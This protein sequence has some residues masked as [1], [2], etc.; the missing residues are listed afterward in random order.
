[1]PI[2]LARLDAPSAANDAQ[3]QPMNTQPTQPA[4]GG[5]DLAKLDAP[6][7]AANQPMQ[8]GGQNN[9]AIAPSQQ[10]AQPSSPSFLDKISDLISP[11]SSDYAVQLLDKSQQQRDQQAQNERVNYAKEAG[12]NVP[13]QPTKFS[14]LAL[15]E[16]ADQPQAKIIALA[17]SRFP[18]MPL[19]QAVKR[20]GVI[21][22]HIVFVGDDGQMY[23]EDQPS[24]GA[25]LIGHSPTIAGN[26]IGGGAGVLAGGGIGSI[27]TGI[28]GAAGGS[29]IGEGIRNA[30]AHYAL[31]ENKTPG[32]IAT[33][34]ATEG[35]LGAANQATGELA[36]RVILPAV[37]KGGSS[38]YNKIVSKFTGKPDINP[39]SVIASPD[40]ASF[41]ADANKLG[42]NVSKAE[43][44][45]NKAD[46]EQEKQLRGLP[47][48]A[49]KFGEAD[50]IRNPQIRNAVTG[51]LDSVAPSTNVPG[52]A[53]S[54]RYA[55]QNAIKQADKARQSAAEPFYQQAYASGAQVDVDPVVNYIND[56]LKTA[57]GQTAAALQRTL[58]LLKPA[59]QP[60][61]QVFD[62]SVEG[63]HNAK[64]EVDHMINAT[65]PDSL[66]RTAKEQLTT[67]KNQLVDQL[68]QA[69]PEYEQG[70]A[71]FAAE[72]APYNQLQNSVIGK[73]ADT[74]DT[75]LK[76]VAST[77]FDPKQ[78]DPR[79]LMQAKQVIQKQN[80]DAWNAITRSYLQQ[81]FEGMKDS[82][83]NGASF[84]KAF[85][86][87]VMG[88][89]KQRDML[90]TALSDNP[91]ALENFK[92]IA[93][94]MPR[95]GIAGDIGSP[96][97]TRLMA[98]AKDSALGGLA[99]GLAGYMSGGEEGAKTGAL[100]GVILGHAGAKAYQKLAFTIMKS[101]KAALAEA[102][103]NPKYAPEMAAIRKLNP[104]SQQA[105]NA[106]TDLV[107]RIG[108]D[109]T[110]NQFNYM[111]NQAPAAAN[112]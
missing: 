12:A 33:G 91:E 99:G 11:P 45:G 94:V 38:I 6:S 80:P 103:L 41:Q 88:T 36:G 35:V 109:E 5:I 76:N 108:E 68:K 2:D 90:M 72:S 73:I 102:V 87:K 98:M 27:A 107:T 48:S 100:T 24:I 62:T 31:D 16:F 44:T 26:I 69:S 66:G 18:N 89:Q 46:I 110:A 56:Q 81:Q 1:M 111:P 112:Q 32:D 60:E 70:R 20:Y 97:A 3:S 104:N 39:E 23:A 92:L 82:V 42:L 13:S 47:G 10:T 37:V 50:Q 59:G 14:A 4:S 65:G 101:K 25:T 83:Q 67:V 77:L 75:Q 93:R 8:M 40:A 58:T 106:L 85:A 17:K 84:G 22:N 74:N 21:N 28:A 95:L 19:D 15:S 53:G 54:V 30:V 71:T 9:S 79:V 29:A 43:A 63:L 78:S 86:S 64:I 7:S 52:A 105:V 96:T 55:A 34:L 51:F 57:K 61:S 49:E